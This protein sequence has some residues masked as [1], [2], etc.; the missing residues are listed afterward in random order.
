MRSARLVAFGSLLA[1]GALLS[2]PVTAATA[3][4]LPASRGVDRPVGPVGVEPARMIEVEPDDFSEA[5]A[6]LPV[7]LQQALA[8]D[9]GLTGAEWLA[10]SEAGNAAADVVADLNEVIEVVDARLENYELV[11]TVETA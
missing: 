7:E 1:V 10:Q 8:R 11:V 9:A 4:D 3:H 6:A 2:A 5:G